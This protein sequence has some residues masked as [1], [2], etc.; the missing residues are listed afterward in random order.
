MTINKLQ[1]VFRKVFEKK[2]LI[3]SAHSSAKDI[4]NWDSLT[5]LELIAAVE[6]AFDVRFSFAE[7]MLFSTV[8]DMIQA[9]EKKSANKK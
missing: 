8:G 2:D 6:E 5:H 7:V 1:E 9:I 4:K 3:I